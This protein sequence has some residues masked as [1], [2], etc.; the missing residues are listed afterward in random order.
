MCSFEL[1]L[2][3][4]LFYI[5]MWEDALDALLLWSWTGGWPPDVSPVCC[6]NK[7]SNAVLLFFKGNRRGCPL[8]AFIDF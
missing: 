7:N 6:S 4:F 3:G 8:L 5:T 2:S 1:I